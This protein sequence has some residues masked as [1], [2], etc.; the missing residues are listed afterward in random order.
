MS[1]QSQALTLVKIKS[2]KAIAKMKFKIP[3][4]MITL[5]AE[6]LSILLDLCPI[7]I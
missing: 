6:E 7:A 2:Y 4:Q 5:T 1:D 3:Y